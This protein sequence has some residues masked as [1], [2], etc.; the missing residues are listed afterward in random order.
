MLATGPAALSR[1]GALAVALAGVGTGVVTGCDLDPRA[2]GPTT[3]TPTAGAPSAPGTDTDL[4]LLDEAR[5]ATAQALALVV[6]V[7]A[8]YPRL[9]G[10]M[11]PL[12]AL[13]E[14]HAEALEDAGPDGPAE[15]PGPEVEGAA[16]SALAR[17][18][19]EEARLRRRLAAWSVQAG[20]GS[21]A[22]LLASMSAGVA[23]HLADVPS[24]P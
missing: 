17:V 22:R 7:G 5:E 4:L 3:P 16:S 8:R 24:G 1:R 12:A 13:H 14:A 20:S 6:T 21:F 10:A 11:R 2:T 19:L 23:A 18:R 15:V 9:R